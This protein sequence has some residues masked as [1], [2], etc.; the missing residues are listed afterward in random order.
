MLID[1]DLWV[2][3]DKIMLLISDDDN[4]IIYGDIY[5]MIEYGEYYYLVIYNNNWMPNWIEVNELL[6]D[7]CAWMYTLMM[8]WWCVEIS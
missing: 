6:Y 8:I 2:C 4:T 1:C 5:M 3:W 7:M